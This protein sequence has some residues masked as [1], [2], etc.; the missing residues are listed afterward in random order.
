MA[1]AAMLR[2][3][4]THPQGIDPHALALLRTFADRD[5]LYARVHIQVQDLLTTTGLVGRGRAVSRVTAPR[6]F[7]AD[8]AARRHVLRGH[9]SDVWT[10]EFSPDGTLLATGSADMTARLWDPATGDHIRTLTGHKASVGGVAFS[11]DG[12]EC[13]PPPA[14]TRQP[15]CGIPPPATTSA[16]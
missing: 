12:T 6:Q 5:D 3:A 16:P 9:T 10:V 8:R 13:S 2:E 4:V 11:P 14:T 7:P 15:G 1:V